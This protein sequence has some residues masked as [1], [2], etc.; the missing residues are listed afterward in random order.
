[1]DSFW[2]SAKLLSVIRCAILLAHYVRRVCHVCY[3]KIH[4]LNWKI[5]DVFINVISFTICIKIHVSKYVRRE[6]TQIS[7]YLLGLALNVRPNARDANP[8]LYVAR[9]VLGSIYWILIV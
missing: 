4:L 3:V 6:P 2:E 9:V 1:M 7:Y 5:K 8:I